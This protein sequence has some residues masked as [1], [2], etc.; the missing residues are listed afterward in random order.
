MAGIF[1]WRLGDSMR[2]YDER[3][4]AGEIPTLE[5]VWEATNIGLSGVSTVCTLFEIA[6]FIGE[7]L[8][9]WTVLFTHTIKL[10][11]ATALLVL[12]SVAHARRID[13]HYTAIGLGLDVALLITAASLA[14]YAALTYRRLAAGANY[15]HSLDVK[16]YGFH[17][18]SYPG[19]AG[20]RLSVRP[21]LEKRLS[22]AASSTRLSFSSAQHHHSRSNSE[23][24]E[25]VALEAVDSSRSSYYRHERDTRFDDY[26]ARRESTDGTATRASDGDRTQD[27]DSGSGAAAKGRPRGRSMLGSDRGLVAVPEEEEAAATLRNTTESKAE[28]DAKDR[29]ALLGDGRRDSDEVDVVQVH[30][31]VDLAERRW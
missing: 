15:A 30:Q 12:D 23:D 6:R 11:C 24:V 20:S 7:S 9:P 3:H 28:Q 27:D 8:T 5:L 21:V 10:T 18:T 4:K 17:D 13:G 25:A 2:S 29:E 16:S 1:A 26:L 31:E 19:S 22:S 14:I